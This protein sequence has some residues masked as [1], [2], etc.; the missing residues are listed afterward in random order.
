MFL[1]RL[2]KELVIPVAVAITL[3]LLFQATI[4]KPYEIPTPSMDPTIRPFDRILANRLIYHFRDISRGDVIVFEPTVEARESCGEQATSDIPFVKRVIGLPGDRISIVSG[5]RDVLINGER[6]TVPSAV[7]N[8]ADPKSQRDAPG[9][10]SEANRVWTVPADSLFVMGDNRPASCYSHV[11]SE[12]YVPIDNVI[13]QAE[14]VYWP[15]SH[16]AF[17]K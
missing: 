16:L 10:A 7:P 13:G 15:P 11:W 1:R 14:V 4:A 17:L 8:D 3:A 2:M 9:L 6:Y 5:T 12:P